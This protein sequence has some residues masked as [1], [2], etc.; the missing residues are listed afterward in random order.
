MFKN[1]FTLK[2]WYVIFFSLESWKW[3][4]KFEVTLTKKV[5]KI[6]ISSTY[7]FIYI[8]LDNLQNK[9]NSTC[10]FENFT[11]IYFKYVILQYNW[12]NSNNMFVWSLK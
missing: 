2:D 7:L 1:I 3:I 10:I 8:Y 5:E 12:H 9:E 11:S 6:N 4:H